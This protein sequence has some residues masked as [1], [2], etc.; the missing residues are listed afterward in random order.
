MVTLVWPATAIVPLLAETESQ[1]DGLLMVQLNGAELKLVSVTVWV[2]DENGPPVNPLADCIKT[3]G[4]TPSGSGK[5]PSAFIKFCPFGV[6]QPVQR[7]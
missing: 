7:S 5:P 3:S 6:P 4:Q 1:A 2:E